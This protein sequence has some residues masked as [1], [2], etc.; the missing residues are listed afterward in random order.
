MR[1]V[2]IHAP[3]DLRV[4]DVA[5]QRMGAADVRVRVA[6]GG[7]CGSDLHYFRHGGFGQVRLKEPMILGHEIAGT[8][9]ECGAEVTAVG[10]GQKVAVNPSLPCRRCEFCQ[11]GLQNHCV[12]MRFFGSA[13]RTPHVQ[14]GFRE[15][16]TCREEQAV[17]V[18]EH[19]S[20]DE[21]V[22]AEPLAVALHAVGR[23]G[24]LLGG[25]VLV[26][27]AGPIGA[28]LV[29]AARCAGAGEIVVTD[30][31]DEPLAISAEHC[32]NRTL[33]VAARP[34]ELASYE[35]GKGAFDVMFE[36][37][38]SGTTIAQG[39]RMLKP[40]GILVCVGQGAEAALQM[41]SVVTKEI[42][43]RGAFRFG[44]EF[45]TAVSFIAERRIDVRRLLTAAIDVDQ[46]REGFELASDKSRSMK[47]QLRF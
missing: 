23:A 24:S 27:G 21:A 41:S 46:A 32:A 44:E 45:A 1:A 26:T 28:L 39:L 5:E 13:M 42:E 12:D 16:L 10:V 22:F 3:D 36:A 30:I 15:F 18:P 6:A 19:V 43:L 33:N 4:D 7:I 17:P 25:R 35:R 20:L 38:G 34:E 2:V 29:G 40:R 37:S 47:V 31:L 9:V 8:V 14:G 11:Q